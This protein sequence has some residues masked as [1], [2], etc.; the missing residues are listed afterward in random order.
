MADY[1]FDIGIYGSD[2]GA[3]LAAVRAAT[4]GHSV[5]RLYWD[6]CDGGMTVGGLGGVMDYIREPHRAAN[7][8][9]KQFFDRAIELWKADNPGWESTSAPVTY[10][11]GWDPASFISA[12]RI[13]WTPN[14]A[15]QILAE[16]VA[17]KNITV[18]GQVWIKECVQN[19]NGTETVVLAN[20]DTYTCKNW[21]DASVSLDLAKKRGVSISYGRDN[22]HT[23]NEERAGQRE[24]AGTDA[25]DSRDAKGNLYPH[26]RT[27]PPSLPEGSADRKTMAYNFRMTVSQHALRV[28]FPQPAGFRSKD[29]DWFVEAN[30]HITKFTSIT[31]HRRINAHLFGTNGF[32]YVGGSWGY[33]EAETREDRLEFW[34]KIFY[35]HAGAYW[36]AQNDPR[37]PL[38]LRNS[39]AAYGLPHDQNQNAGQYFGVPGWSSCL[40]EREVATMRGDDVMTEWNYVDTPTAGGMLDPINLHGYPADGHRVHQWP[41]G[42]GGW[43]DYEGSVE[44]RG[45]GQYQVGLRHVKAPK[46]QA[47]NLV[48]SWGFSQ[49]RSLLCSSR[50]Q[51][52]FMQQAEICAVIQSLAVERGISTADVTYEMLKPELTAIGA[53]LTPSRPS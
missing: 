32:S 18:V 16:L 50:I 39:M 31:S 41:T 45:G 22:L 24:I 9:T 53:Y 27:M 7:G 23:F 4:R 40:Y 35:I 5:V 47:P 29:F 52:P 3:T 25:Y 28:P 12:G 19:A 37:M 10:W 44:L 30:Q 48:V 8:S 26:H 6:P 14:T 1:T 17:G 42:A 49:S 11:D 38:A 15:R 34:N 2:G 13:Y 20:G 21:Q 46:G 33:P 43:T 51:P 36:I